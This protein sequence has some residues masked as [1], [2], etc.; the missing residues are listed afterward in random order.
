[1]SS[2]PDRISFLDALRRLLEARPGERMPKLVVNP[3]RPGR[4]G[5]RVRKRRPK[6]Y[7]PM[8]KPCRELRKELADKDIAA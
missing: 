1:M 3:S 8:R 4:F 2:A 7:P 5:P 6:P